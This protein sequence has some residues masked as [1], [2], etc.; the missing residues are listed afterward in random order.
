MCIEKTP[1]EQ[2]ID[3]HGH[4]CPEI[5]LGFRISQIAS[6]KLGIRPSG[7]AELIGETGI[8]SCAIDAL[9]VLNRCTVGRGTLIINNHG[10]HLYKF[11]YTGT[12]TLLTISIKPAV[13]QTLMSVHSTLNP[14]QKQNKSLEVI[15]Q[16]LTI[17]EEDFCSVSLTHGELQ[18]T[19]MDPKWVTCS[20]CGDLVQESFTISK[21]DH[22]YCSE[23]S[24]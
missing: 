17:Q 14:R 15:Q 6:R 4:T 8:V 7:D 12:E 11:H 3:F 2:V 19:L 10:K 21:D 5:A 9:Q 16:L 1:W 23:C 18:K 20:N 13:I 24:C 22:L